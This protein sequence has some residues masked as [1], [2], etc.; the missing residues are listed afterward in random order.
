MIDNALKIDGWMSP[1]DLTFLADVAVRSRTIIEV[2]CYK[3]RS[4]RVLADNC[5]GVVYAVD[6]W[7]ELYYSNEDKAIFRIG[8]NVYEQFVENVKLQCKNVIIFRGTLDQF[9]Y[10]DEVDFIFLDG[11]HRYEYVKKDI[12]NALKL[13]KKGGVLA[14]H[15]YKYVE[16]PGVRQAVNER[17][18]S[19]VS[20]TED[21]IWWITKE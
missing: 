19:Y 10:P 5:K 1:V 17:F 15:D 13:L 3:G 2:G 16:W 21:Q 8:N 14:G 7:P 11:D 18:S 6:P 20:T 9:I 4:T 12:E